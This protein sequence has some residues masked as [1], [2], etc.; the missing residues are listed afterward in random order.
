MRVA[1]PIG[2]ALT[3]IGVRASW[4]LHGAQRLEAA[5]FSTAWAWDHFLSR[6]VRTHPVLECWTTLAAA[7]AVT[8]RLGVGSFVT[9]VMNRHPAVL[10]RM[11]ATVADVAAG[12]RVELGIGTGGYPDELATYGIPFPDVTERAARLE[13]AVAVMRALFTG[14]PVDHEGRYFRLEAAMAYPVPRPAPRIVVAGRTPAGARLAARVGDAWTCSADEYARLRPSFEAELAAAGR[15]RSAVAV[16]VAVPL[17]GRTADP[18]DPVLAD[19]GGVAAT[20]QE[21]GADEVVIPWVRSGQLDALL[22]AGER[23]GLGA[24]A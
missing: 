2:A 17:A 6:G 14:G 20:W 21:R 1:L 4:W 22:A 11:V 16:V 7:A 23:A 12:R 19:L 8:T 15:D 3:T 5:G 24:P 18:G 10:A 9:N 13:E